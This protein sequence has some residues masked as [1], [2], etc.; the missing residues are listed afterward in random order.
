MTYR[1]R[2]HSMADPTLY[3]E[4]DE[5]DDWRIKDPIEHFKLMAIQD[6]TITE[7]EF[8][9][10]DSDVEATIADAVKFAEESPEPEIDSMYDHVYV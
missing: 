6:G 3:R 5:V 9:E 2:G 8:N 7:D 4:S 10:I 1:Y